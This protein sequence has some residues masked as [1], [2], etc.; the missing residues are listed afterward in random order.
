MVQKGNTNSI[1]FNGELKKSAEI[2][3]RP[4]ALGA[5]AQN[6][7]GRSPYNGDILLRDAR[8]ADFRIYDSALTDAEVLEAADITT[9]AALNGSAVGD[10][11]D[12]AIA[13]MDF[14]FSDVRGDVTLPTVLG[15]GIAGSWT[16]S[17]ASLISADGRVTRPAAGEVSCYSEVSIIRCDVDCGRSVSKKSCLSEQFFFCTIMKAFVK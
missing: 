6:W 10:A 2:S 15:Q 16:T 11:I 5:T 7:L 14:D 17:D 9:L 12:S 1:Y 13:D 8:Y 4:S 3:L